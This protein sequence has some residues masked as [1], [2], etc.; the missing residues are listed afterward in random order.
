MDIY[1]QKI[2]KIIQ[3]ILGK[4]IG[5]FLFGSRVRKDNV[6][7]SDYDVGLLSTSK[8]DR[9][10][11]QKINELIEESTI[12]FKVD[13]IDFSVVKKEFKEIATQDIEIWQN[14]SLIQSLIKNL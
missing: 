3:S 5:V 13:I 1:S 11:L 10:S 14:P 9:L 8:V 7:F 12:P 6:E 2:L 4:D